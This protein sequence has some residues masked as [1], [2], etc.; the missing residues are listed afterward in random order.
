[1][2]R[3]YFPC[4]ATQI[5]DVGAI[6]GAAPTILQTAINVISKA[7]FLFFLVPTYFVS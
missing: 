3:K 5:F 4:T 1:M 6:F 2:T 7:S